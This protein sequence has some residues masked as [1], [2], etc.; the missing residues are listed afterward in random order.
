MIDMRTLDLVDLP[1][2]T[3]RFGQVELTVREARQLFKMMQQLEAIGNK[4]G[5]YVLIR[6][7]ID[8]IQEDI[9]DILNFYGRIEIVGGSE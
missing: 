1:R 3:N 7:Q 4:K 2:K 6:N 8:D 5:L 9:F